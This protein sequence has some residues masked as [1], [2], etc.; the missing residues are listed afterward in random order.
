MIIITQFS[1]LKG[2]ESIE[3]MNGGTYGESPHKIID[4]ISKKNSI[5][6]DYN[7]LNLHLWISKEQSGGP[8]LLLQQ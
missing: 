6:Y 4:K 2:I 3:E 1:D 5:S 8:L 7:K